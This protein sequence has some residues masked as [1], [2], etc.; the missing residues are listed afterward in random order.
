MMSHGHELGQSWVPEDGIARH[1]DV[2][3]VEVNELSVVVIALPEGDR[4]ADLPYRDR[5]TIGDS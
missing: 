1:T 4:K 5:G 2:R 3:N